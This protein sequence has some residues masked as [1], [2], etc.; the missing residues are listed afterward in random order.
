M[1]IKAKL[2]SPESDAI[3]RKAL[4]Q[5][6]NHLNH[7]N[8]D[9]FEPQDLDMLIRAATKDL[10][11]FDKERHDEFKRYEMMKEHERREYLK[12]LNEEQKKEEEARYEE[13]KK[14]HKDHPKINHPVS[15]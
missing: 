10:E 1:L 14:K 11:N 9:S 2:S 15:R 13:M 7:M 8:P 12:T 4:I 6:F 5:Q 3:D